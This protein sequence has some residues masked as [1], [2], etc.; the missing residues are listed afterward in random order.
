[1]TGVNSR[2]QEKL[3]HGSPSPG[4]R[5]SKLITVAAYVSSGFVHR[6][7]HNK[8]EGVVFRHYWYG[9]R[10]LKRTAD[11]QTLSLGQS[12]QS[13]VP[14]RIL[15]RWPAG[16][17]EL[18]RQSRG[19]AGRETNPRRI[20]KRRGSHRSDGDSRAGKPH[21]RAPSACLGLQGRFKS[22][23]MLA[24]F[25]WD[26]TGDKA[27]AAKALELFRFWFSSGTV[28]PNPHGLH[29]PAAG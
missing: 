16:A 12:R 20:V 18:C 5:W 4:V 15:C 21:R 23:C 13:D 19:E 1:M 29:S 26:A 22:T 7:S 27:D 17:E 3:L 2:P 8:C 9:D 28:D 25:I 10:N 11:S 14:A 6:G 24:S